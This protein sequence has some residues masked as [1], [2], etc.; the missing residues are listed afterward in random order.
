MNVEV[1]TWCCFVTLCYYCGIITLCYYCGITSLLSCYII[2]FLD[3][4]M[5]A[6]NPYFG[7]GGVG[8]PLPHGAGMPGLVSNDFLT[9]HHQLLAQMQMLSFYQTQIY[10]KKLLEAEN[11]VSAGSNSCCR[12]S[13]IRQAI[14]HYT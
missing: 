11:Q 10:Q 5:F 9:G 8:G 4:K 6:A 14:H 12:H 7:A 3:S 2:V 1:T 13:T